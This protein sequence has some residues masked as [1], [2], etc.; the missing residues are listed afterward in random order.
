MKVFFIKSSINIF[1]LLENYAG[2]IYLL[3]NLE[4]WLRNSG[5]YKTL[6]ELQTT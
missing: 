1:F 6:T 2:G 5:I 3:L 4:L